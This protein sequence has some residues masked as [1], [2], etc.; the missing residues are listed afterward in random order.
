MTRTRAAGWMVAFVLLGLIGGGVLRRGPDGPDRS[1][2]SHAVVEATVTRVV[3]G[4]T[5]KVRAAGHDDT[6]R[7]I[8]V[9]TPETKKPGTPI[10]C[11]G[12]AASAFNQRLVQGRGVTLRTDAEP[13]DRYG[14]LLAYVYRRDDGLFVNASLVRRGFAT[15]LTIAPNLGHAGELAGLERE[16]RRG[17]VGLWRACR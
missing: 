5:V 17:D 1:I 10:Q 9:D 8:G 16:A 6:V 13:R 4:D 2:G 7:Y 15:T 12:K 11:F 14:R 3:D